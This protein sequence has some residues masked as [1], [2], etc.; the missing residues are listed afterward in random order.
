MHLDDCTR[1]PD[2]GEES[3]RA[4]KE[5]ASMFHESGVSI[6]PVLEDL[7]ARTHV[8]IAGLY[9]REGRL[10]EAET[11]LLKAVRCSGS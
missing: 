1:R 5:A 2:V 10:D 11:S 6:S 7:E 3:E 4:W 9:V 8:N